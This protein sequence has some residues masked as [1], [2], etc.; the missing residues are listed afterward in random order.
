MCA[1][2]TTSEAAIK[3]FDGVE[4]AFVDTPGFDDPKR[5]D[6]T[7]IL[8]DVTDWTANNLGGTTKVTTALFLHSI[9]TPKMYSSAFRNFK[10]VLAAY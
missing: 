9:L 7:T 1:P 5:L 4:I 6:A 8:V 10:N 3:I 2:N